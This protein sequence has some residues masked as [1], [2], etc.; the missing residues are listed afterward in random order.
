M[1]KAQYLVSLAWHY[2]VRMLGLEKVLIGYA[3]RR[4]VAYLRRV[5]LG[6]LLE[7]DISYGVPI[8]ELPDRTKVVDLARLHRLVASGR[9]RSIREYGAGTSTIVMAHATAKL[10]TNVKFIIIEE[11][12]EWANFVS[13]HFQEIGCEVR[14][15]HSEYMVSA[16]NIAGEVDLHLKDAAPEVPDFIYVDGPSLAGCTGDIRSMTLADGWAEPINVD[17]HS[18]VHT[19]R[20][21]SVVLFDDRPASYWALQRAIR[22]PYI[23]WSSSLFD[24]N[25]VTLL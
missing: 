15:V 25:K 10:S 19:M 11:S 7:K 23:A 2:V 14:F 12:A 6:S 13:G 4:S 16:G 5:G 9:F 8:L 22:R 17:F 20:K 24:S 3:C 18:V 21:G 1:T